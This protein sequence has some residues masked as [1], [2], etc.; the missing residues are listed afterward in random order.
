MSIVLNT[1]ASATEATFNLS[2]ANDNLRK[3]IAR[4]SSG[5][6]ITKPTD[7]A[8]GLAVAYKLQSSVKRTE[9]ALNNHQNA[10]SF[11][12]VQDGV[13]EVVGEIVGRMAE[14]RTMAADVSKNTADI[15][16]YSKEFLELQDQLNQMKRQKF[17]G[18]ELFAVEEEWDQMQGVNKEQLLINGVDYRGNEGASSIGT[19]N[20]YEYFDNPVQGNRT[21]SS[22][23]KY[24]FQLF[25]APSGEAD[26]GNIKLNIINLQMLL[27]IKDPSAIDSD[28]SIAT[29]VGSAPPTLSIGSTLNLG[30]FNQ[31]ALTDT[32]D[33]DKLT[34]NTG[35]G[36]IKDI[37]EISIEEFTNIIEKVADARAEN[38]AEQQRVNQSMKLQQNNLVNL[39]AAHGRIMD[40]DV[41]LESTRLARHSVTVQA[42]A[43]MVAQANQMTS[44]ALTLL[45]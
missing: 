9:A 20:T 3:S 27:G 33:I 22:F 16:N 31:P 34:N 2:K 12:Q 45:Q 1:N 35:T 14:L 7:D 24:E 41:A 43:A 10:L 25:T 19:K 32:E 28:L 21:N 36:Y 30:G 6:R 15:E 17:N 37:T 42:S 8:G 11:L 38:G 26:D 4:L 29:A 18:V 40:T 44:V 23:D 39:E 13:L 5:N